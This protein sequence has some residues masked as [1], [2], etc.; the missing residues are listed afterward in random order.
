MI[1][2]KHF[3]VEGQLEFR[4]LLCVPRRVPFD[5]FE[6][7]RNANNDSSWMC[8]AFF[9]GQDCDELIPERLK[10]VKGV[11]DLE[12]VSLEYFARFCVSSRKIL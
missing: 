6:A 8:V 1:G 12:G 11:A 10:F 2:R 3:S 4:E 7:R 5:L 9:I